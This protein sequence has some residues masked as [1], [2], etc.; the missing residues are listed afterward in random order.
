MRQYKLNKCDFQ[1]EHAAAD[2][3]LI[4]QGMEAQSDQSGCTSDSFP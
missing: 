4:V 1:N 3:L 2:A